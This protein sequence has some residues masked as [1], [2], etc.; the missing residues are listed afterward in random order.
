MEPIPW[1]DPQPG[2]IVTV[3]MQDRSGEFRDCEAEVLA[4]F[5][6][7]DHQRTIDVAVKIKDETIRQNGVTYSGP[8]RGEIIGWRWPHQ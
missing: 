6:E 7:H 1:V 5:D 2:D 4:S 8:R 3:G